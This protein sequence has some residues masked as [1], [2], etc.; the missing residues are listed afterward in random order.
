MSVQS[1]GRQ[2]RRLL[3]VLAVAAVVVLPAPAYG[4]GD[5]EPDEDFVLV[6]QAI[7]LIVNT[8]DNHGAIADKVDDAVAAA[9]STNVQ[10]PL[11]ERAGSR[12][13]GGLFSARSD[14]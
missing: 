8:P 3:V 14:P 2:P 4:H 10:L 6:L 5:D 11:V 13:A 1:A 7:A 12:R 9:D